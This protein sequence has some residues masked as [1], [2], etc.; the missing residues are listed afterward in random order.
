VST[1]PRLWFDGYIEAFNRSDFAGFGAYYAD[2]VEFIGQA[3]RFQG[4][5]AVLDFYR[6]VK[7]RM[8]EVLAVRQFVGVPDRL[9]VEIDTRLEARMDW[10][11]FP[12]GPLKAGDRI[13][14]ISFVFYD[15]SGGLFT[16]IRSAGYRRV[17]GG[18]AP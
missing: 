6:T 8:S 5:E 4:R 7:T 13:G 9:A 1:E 11:D 3:G 2:D 14:V 17:V 10:P 18:W 16:R 15:V 12:T